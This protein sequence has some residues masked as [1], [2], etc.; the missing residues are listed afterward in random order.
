[1]KDYPKTANENQKTIVREILNN[2]TQEELGDYNYQILQ[3]CGFTH[4]SDLTEKQSRRVLQII[5]QY[6]PNTVTKVHT[7]SNH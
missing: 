5:M 2:F 3:N 7:K 4:S 6:G 1:M